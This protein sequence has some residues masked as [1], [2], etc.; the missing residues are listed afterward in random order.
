MLRRGFWGPQAVNVS[1]Q[2][3]K[4][5]ELALSDH[6][7]TLVQRGE[8]PATALWLIQYMSPGLNGNLPKSNADTAWPHAVAGHQTLFSPAWSLASDDSLAVQ[9]NNVLNLLTY[10]QE[11]LV[12][13]ALADYPNYIS[14]GASESRV[15]G[16]NVERLIDIK[17][18]YDPDCTIH[19]GRVF[20]SS[21]CIRGGWANIFV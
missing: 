15:W 18:K 16:D 17:Q 21:G 1:S 5:A 9:A 8:F 14:P 10:A 2:Y 7:N 20:A 19:S 11:A 6:V 13:P 4:N 3:L 12:G